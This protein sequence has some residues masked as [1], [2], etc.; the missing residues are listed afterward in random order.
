[1]RIQI[2]G[3][4]ALSIALTATAIGAPNNGVFKDSRDGQK[5]KK[6]KIGKQVWMA[7][8]LNYKMEGSY[9]Y[10]NDETHCEK[11]GRLYE[12]DA[13]MKA[14]PKGWHLPDKTEF[15]VLFDAVGGIS[16]AAKMLKSTDGWDV[17]MKGGRF[18]TGGGT[19]EYGFSALP[20]GIKAPVKKGGRFAAETIA[21]IFQC[22]TEN[23]NDESYNFTFAKGEDKVTVGDNGDKSSALSV[24]CVKD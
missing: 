24:R 12:W 10:E 18:V 9:C 1:M 5:Y 15:E 16:T 23:K 19:D 4:L 8:N 2:K 21:T 17:V 22:S 6:V 13:A 3:I 14:C 11:Y 7:E 20:A